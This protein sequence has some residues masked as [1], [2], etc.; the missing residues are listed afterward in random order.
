MA[1]NTQ[2]CRMVLLPEALVNFITFVM[3]CSEHAQSEGLPIDPVALKRAPVRP[4]QL[5]VAALCVLITK[6]VVIFHALFSPDHSSAFVLAA[7]I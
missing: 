1:E 3:E 7:L 6:N 2:L 4:D 5:T